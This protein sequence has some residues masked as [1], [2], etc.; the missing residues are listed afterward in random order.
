MKRPELPQTVSVEVRGT[1]DSSTT[2][3]FKFTHTASSSFNQC[4]SQHLKR[5]IPTSPYSLGATTHRS[6]L[7]TGQK[8]GRRPVKDPMP[9]E[10][11]PHLPSYERWKL[12]EVLASVQGPP[13]LQPATHT[14]RALLHV[15]AQSRSIF[16][17]SSGT[18]L[19]NRP[20]R[21]DFLAARHL[22]LRTHILKCLLHKDPQLVSFGCSSISDVHRPCTVYL[23]E[24]VAGGLKQQSG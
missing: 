1:P 16:L 13:L 6:P 12:T 17:K 10:M 23:T 8:G 20:S 11:R 15:T 9:H 19:Q 5:R 2:R 22:H 4:I 21:I 14:D 3:E 24:H 18:H 7:Q